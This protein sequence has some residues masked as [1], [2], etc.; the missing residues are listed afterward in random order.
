VFGFDVVSAA[1]EMSN[2]IQE[3]ED[4]YVASGI[5]IKDLLSGEHPF[6]INEVDRILNASI[7]TSHHVMQPVLDV[8]VQFIPNSDRYAKDIVSEIVNYLLCYST[9]HNFIV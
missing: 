1:N 4:L 6:V 9:F 8:F 7:N 2:A 5:E 3:L